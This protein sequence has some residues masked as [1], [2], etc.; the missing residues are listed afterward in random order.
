MRGWVTQS[1][2]S[3]SLTPHSESSSASSHVLT[4]W[5]QDWVKS[6]V[7]VCRCVYFPMD[8]GAVWRMAPCLGGLSSL[9]RRGPTISSCP[10]STAP[11]DQ[12]WLTM[13][14]H[15]GLSPTP[16]H[17]G[18]HPSLLSPPLVLLPPS[19]LV[20]PLLPSVTNTSLLSLHSFVNS[21]TTFRLLLAFLNPCYTSGRKC[22]A[23]LISAL[24]IFFPPLGTDKLSKTPSPNAASSRQDLANES[25]FLQI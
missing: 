13:A 15:S 2:A 10:Y 20:L 19:S 7:E 9:N 14:P 11:T 3:Y 17:W 1:A 24:I 4:L 5:P 16:G 6:L 18:Q 8:F 21:C 12:Q 22:T 25:E 23:R